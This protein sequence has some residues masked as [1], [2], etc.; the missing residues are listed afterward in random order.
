MNQTQNSSFSA[1]QPLVKT[2]PDTVRV[3]LIL[4]VGK[5]KDLQ[6]EIETGRTLDKM[7]GGQGRYEST[8]ADKY[9]G[10]AA[11]M[12]VKNDAFTTINKWR[13]RAPAGF[14]FNALM[15][16]FNCPDPDSITLSKAAFEFEHGYR[17][18][19]EHRRTTQN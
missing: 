2:L 12:Q 1:E 13:D 9:G 11:L 6:E 7:F 4:A 18:N 19:L 15:A 8:I 10:C 5:L 14:D 16:E 3:S 17:A